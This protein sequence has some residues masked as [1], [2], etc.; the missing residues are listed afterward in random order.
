MKFTSKNVLCATMLATVFSIGSVQAKQESFIDNKVD[1]IP[2]LKT[3]TEYAAYDDTYWGEASCTFIFGADYDVEGRFSLTVGAQR[4]SGP[5]PG[6]NRAEYR[7]D[8][9][10]NAVLAANAAIETPARTIQVRTYTQTGG[11]NS[12]THMWPMGQAYM[13]SLY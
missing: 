12:P 4:V 5:I 10:N 7:R 8:N 3:G 2:G 13:L 11:V 9:C 6:P 1:A